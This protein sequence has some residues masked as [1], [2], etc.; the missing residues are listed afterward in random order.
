MQATAE[1]KEWTDEALMALPRN[2]RKHE[3]LGGE[4]VVSP[5][6]FQH[7]YL[8]LR[9]ASALMAF[10]LKHRLGMVVDSSTG[11]RMKNGDCLSPDI[12]FVGKERLPGRKAISPGFFQG[13]PDL[14]VEVISPGESQKRLEQ[15]LAQYFAEGTRLAWVVNPKD[16]T[17]CVYT[18]PEH[19]TTL[20]EGDQLEGAP[21]LPGFAFPLK[22]LFEIPDFEGK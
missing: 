4:L 8:S 13:A 3:L 18:S 16:R 12:S 2:G 15:K 1:R 22:E 21:V 9:L 11:F 19:S 10:A 5:T 20:H 6:G 17:V 7:G 14:A